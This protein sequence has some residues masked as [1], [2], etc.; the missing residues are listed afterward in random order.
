MGF[1]YSSV[2]SCIQPCVIYGFKANAIFVVQVEQFGIPTILSP[3]ARTEQVG[4]MKTNSVFYTVCV[5]VCLPCL[6]AV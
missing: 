2:L 1:S 4:S 5:C 6:R 3:F